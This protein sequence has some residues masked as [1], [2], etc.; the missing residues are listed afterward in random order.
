MVLRTFIH[1]GGWKWL[2]CDEPR[3]SFVDKADAEVMIS[4][5]MFISIIHNDIIIGASAIG[6]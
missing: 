5:P 2:T 3:G 1:H 4:A 6:R